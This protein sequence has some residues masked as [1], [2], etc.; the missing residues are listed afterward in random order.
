MNHGSFL[1]AHCDSNSSEYSTRSPK[2]R[3]GRSSNRC[4]IAGENG[5]SRLIFDLSHARSRLIGRSYRQYSLSS[6]LASLHDPTS[7]RSSRNF[8]E[9]QTATSRTFRIASLVVSSSTARLQSFR[10][11]VAIRRRGEKTSKQRTRAL[12]RDER[13]QEL[14]K[15]TLRYS[16]LFDSRRSWTE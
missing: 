10:I 12:K 6:T 8:E 15:R 9:T 11:T 14:L 1:I 3:I 13:G 5:T 4:N 2:L 7:P 16:S